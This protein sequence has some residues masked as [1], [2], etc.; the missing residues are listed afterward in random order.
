MVKANQIR[1]KKKKKTRDKFIKMRSL[2]AAKSCLDATQVRN[3]WATGS[4]ASTPVTATQTDS[5]ASPGSSQTD[6]LAKPREWWL[7]NVL[8][9]GSTTSFVKSQYRAAVSQHQEGT[10]PSLA[11]L[12]T[13]VQTA[14]ADTGCPHCSAV[15]WSS[16]VKNLWKLPRTDSSQSSLLS[17]FSLNRHQDLSSAW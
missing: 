12:H 17:F 3:P 7:L 8:G 16:A 14:G 5:T 15:C 1:L 2:V 13:P 9:T 11:W 4:G 6:T 10:E